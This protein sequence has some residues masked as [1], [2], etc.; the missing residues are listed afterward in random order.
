LPGLLVISLDFELYWGVRD[1]SYVRAYIPNLVGARAA[2][3]A[4]LDVFTR[5]GIHATWATVGFL[6]CE[7][8]AMLREHVP[9]VL[10]K[11]AD[12]RLSPYSDLPPP[13]ARETDDSIWFAPSLIRRVAD[14]PNQEIATHTFSHYLCM[15]AGQDSTSFREDLRAAWDV[16][17]KAG[18]TLR[19]LVFPRNQC[20]EEYLQVARDVGITSYRGNP[21]SWLHQSRR[22]SQKQ[23]MSRAFRLADSYLRLTRPQSYQKPSTGDPVKIPASRFLRPYQVRLHRLEA[24]RLRRIKDELT[25]AAERGLVYHLWWHPHNFGRDTANNV[26]FLEAILDH[27][28]FLHDKYGMI[29]MNMVEIADQAARTAGQRSIALRPL[30]IDKSRHCGADASIGSAFPS[31]TEAAGRNS[32]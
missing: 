23:V 9:R 21:G 22:S 17:T 1:R 14:T 28:R 29:S 27:Y 5:F 4:I 11:Y 6:F 16:A 31:S 18:L 7:T 13:E 10:P 24:L 2:I 20:V 15:E 8:G 3:P 19:S 26:A 30:K 32:K 12:R 25:F